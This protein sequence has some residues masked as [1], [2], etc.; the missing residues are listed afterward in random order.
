MRKIISGVERDPQKHRGSAEAQE[1]KG[2]S[3]AHLV[4]LKEFWTLL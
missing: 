1:Q 4:N 3:L 2:H